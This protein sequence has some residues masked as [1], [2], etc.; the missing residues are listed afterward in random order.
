MALIAAAAVT[1]N[2]PEGFSIEH[3]ESISISYLRKSIPKAVWKH[4]CKRGDR[5]NSNRSNHNESI[6][7][8]ISA[9]GI[10]L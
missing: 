9:F 7:K 8:K 5:A 1:R 2:V 4:C 3:G 6:H 10:T